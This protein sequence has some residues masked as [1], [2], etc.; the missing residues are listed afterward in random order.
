MKQKYK[1]AGIIRH[2]DDSYLLNCL[3][4][5]LVIALY[6]TQ[7]PKLPMYLT[8]LFRHP[9][10]EWLLWL[11]IPA[12][13]YLTGLHTEALGSAQRVLLATGLITAKTNTTDSTRYINASYA[14][15]LKTLDGKEVSLASLKG[16]VIFMNVW[17]TWCPP[18]IAEMPGI[19]KLY[20]QTKPDEVAFVMLSVDKNF[21]KLQKFIRRKGYTFPVYQLADGTIPRMYASE[22]IPATFVISAQGKLVLR[23][24]GM[25]NYNTSDFRN[26][27]KAHATRYYL[28]KGKA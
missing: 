25:A 7:T 2:P 16:K 12:I 10:F 27:L 28:R 22:A 6:R 21:D 23:H 11:G 19:Q 18:C 4:L 15:A 3:A 9:A 5:H 13:L 17:A 26:F 8:R 20:D 1:L 24:E 14:V